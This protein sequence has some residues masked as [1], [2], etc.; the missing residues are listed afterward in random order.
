[1]DTISIY[2]KLSVSGRAEAV[3]KAL[4]LGLLSAAD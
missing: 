2:R 4:S 1:V 3:A